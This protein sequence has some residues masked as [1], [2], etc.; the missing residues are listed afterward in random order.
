MLYLY[1]S[2]SSVTRRD[3]HEATFLKHKQDMREWERKLQEGEERLCQS[4]RHINEREEKLNELNRMFKEKE[5]ELDEEQKKAELANLT[6]KK[7][8]DVVN[9]K[10]AELTVKEEVSVGIISIA[11]T[12]IRPLS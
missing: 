10:L 7:K 9:K 11:P 8:E 2:F 12:I 6:L 3:A 5:S 4:R 1:I